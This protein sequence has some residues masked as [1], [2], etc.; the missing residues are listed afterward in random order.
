MIVVPGSLASSRTATSAVTADGLTG[1][2][3]SSTTK[4]RSASPSKAR[5]M[6][7]PCCR[8]AAWR[9]TRLAGSSG[10]ASWL[11][12]VP[13]SSKYS[14]T[15]SSGSPARTTGTVC[16]PMPLP[17]STTTFSGRIAREVDQRVQV[18]RVVGEDVARGDRAD[19]RRAPG[20]SVSR[21]AHSRIV[22]QA[23]V[24]ADRGRAGAAELDAVVLRRVVA[25]GE[26]RAGQVQ[27][28]GREV[29]QVG[30]AEP[31]LHDVDAP[32]DHALGEGP[33]QRDRRTRACRAP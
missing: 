24:L 9:S 30:R 32:A 6:S 19:P 21:S 10:F 7:A 25:G 13:S 16:P 4:H 27:R 15:I 14:G 12:K 11:G 5:P 33:R 1:S 20:R 17:A 28:A 26:H 8:T 29:Q 31:G 3:C 23:G 22:H 2:P 18:R